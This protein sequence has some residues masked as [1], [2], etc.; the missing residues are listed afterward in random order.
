MRQ[1]NPYRILRTGGS[2]GRRDDDEYESDEEVHKRSF[3][4]TDAGVDVKVTKVAE[5]PLELKVEYGPN[6]ARHRDTSKTWPGATG[7][8]VSKPEKDGVVVYVFKVITGTSDNSP[9]TTHELWM[10]SASDALAAEMCKKQLFAWATSNGMDC[11][12]DCNN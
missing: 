1:Q 11:Q 2:A 3:Q 8:Q 10:I 12:E 4:Y 5:K 7:F 6:N 9:R